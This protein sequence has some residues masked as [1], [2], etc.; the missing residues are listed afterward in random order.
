[1][2]VPAIITVFVVMM[3]VVMAMV[4]GMIMVVTAA[5]AVVM[6][7]PATV[8]RPRLLP[9]ALPAR[10]QHEEKA[11]GQH[12]YDDD[13][14]VHSNSCNQSDCR[15]GQ[16]PCRARSREKCANRHGARA[17]PAR[18]RFVNEMD[19]TDCISLCNRGGCDRGPVALRAD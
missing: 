11:G 13:G 3:M 16:Q 5:R 1:M 14:Q 7:A 15:P 4:M 9:T 19:C 10:E 17:V 18:S 12:E 6:A 2:L 8:V